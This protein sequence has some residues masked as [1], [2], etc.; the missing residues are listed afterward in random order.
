MDGLFYPV[1]VSVGMVLLFEHVWRSPSTSWKQSE[2]WYGSYLIAYFTLS[3]I[4][5]Q[6]EHY[7]NFQFVLDL[8]EI[9][10]AL[11]LYYALLA[12]S[13]ISATPGGRWGHVY[14]ALAV[15]PLLHLIWDLQAS[16]GVEP[17]VWSGYVVE[18]FVLAFGVYTAMRPVPSVPP[19][20]IL[21]VL[22]VGV[23]ITHAPV[24]EK[25]FGNTPV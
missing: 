2:T 18:A 22:A 16:S 13:R 4:E 7:T 6:V 19:L 12:P 3:F 14:G 9:G 1:V 25:F 15:M 24:L 21:A 20:A 11:W 5:G 8:F 17:L 10:I 23:G